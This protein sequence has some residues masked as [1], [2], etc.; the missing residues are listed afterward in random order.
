VPPGAIP[1][2]GHYANWWT[3]P[4]QWAQAATR[5]KNGIY[6][7]DDPA[8]IVEHNRL[9][10]AAG[11]VPLVSWWGAGALAGDRFLNQYLP[12]A[13]PQLGLLYEAIGEGRLAPN[14]SRIDFNDGAVVAQFIGEMEHLRDAY[15]DGP[16]GHRF[17]R[18]DGRPVVFIWITGAFRGPFDAVAAGVREFVYLVGSEFHIPAYIPAGHG[19]IVRG[20]DAITAYGFY[21]TDRYP[22]EM[23]DAF[24]AG[25]TNGIRQWREVLTAEAPGVQLIPPMTFAYDERNIPDRVGYVFRSSSEVARRYAKLVRSYVGTPGVLPMAYCTSLTE[26]IEGS[27]IFP[28]DDPE[29]PD[30]YSIVREEFFSPGP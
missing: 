8:V 22:E 15:F 16:S 2:L 29:R 7:S 13:G 23:N 5:P 21:D 1:V 25:Y 24:L 9:M 12:I 30:Y 11:I 28:T 14:G 3:I 18:V 19:Q 26:W 6:S 20:L 10:L 4:G 17:F 27:P